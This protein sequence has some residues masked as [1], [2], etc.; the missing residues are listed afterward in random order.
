MKILTNHALII[1]AIFL[2]L[3]MLNSCSDK[4]SGHEIL[5][6]K[7]QYDVPVIN[8]DPRLDWWINNIEGSRR[9]PFLQRIMEAAG[10]GEFSVYDYFNQPLTPLQVQ[11]QIIDTVY[12][13]L[14]R[15]YPPYEEY[16][17]MIVSAITYR[18]IT[19]IRFLEEWSWEPGSLEINKKVLAIGPLVQYTVAGE[20]FNRLLFWIYPGKNHPVK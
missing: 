1:A 19:K 10:Q 9:E 17:T 8:N 6:S 20:N 18:D 13:T 14:V 5:A 15:N 11:S 2:T 4:S 7:I 16:D 3:A 12:R